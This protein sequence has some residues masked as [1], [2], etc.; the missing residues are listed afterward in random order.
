VSRSRNKKAILP[1]GKEIIYQGYEMI[2]ILELLKTY[3]EEEIK[4]ERKEIPSISYLGEDNKSH[5]YFPDIYIPNGNLIIE[6]KSEWTMKQNL[7][8]NLLKSR[9]ARDL[10]YNFEFWICSDK[11]VLEIIK[12]K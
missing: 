9:A 8:K 5:R 2:A 4:S 11:E 12:E 6:V 7:E 1:S 3:S 10:G